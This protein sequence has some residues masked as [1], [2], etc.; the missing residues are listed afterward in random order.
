[1]KLSIFLTILFS[2]L[3]NALLTGEAASLEKNCGNGRVDLNESCDDGNMR[4]LDGCS[5]TCSIEETFEC[6]YSTE[7]ARSICIKG[8]DR[9]R[10][11]QELE[12]PILKSY[13]KIPNKNAVEIIFYTIS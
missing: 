7:L 1:M 8:A 2:V 5:S 4:S 6:R 10:I 11:L 13:L 9:A 3:G 12:P